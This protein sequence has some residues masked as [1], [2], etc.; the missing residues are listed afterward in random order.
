MAEIIQK[1]RIILHQ[2]VAAIDDR[3]LK[4]AEEIAEV[5]DLGYRYKSGSE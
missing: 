2:K 5:N 4:D 1:T 3:G